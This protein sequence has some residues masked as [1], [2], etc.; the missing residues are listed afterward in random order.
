MTKDPEG[1][2]AFRRDRV[3]GL[4]IAAAVIAFGL[5]EAPRM[6]AA[7][8]TLDIYFVDVEGGQA[9]LV[10]TPA[11]ETLLVDTGFPGS[12]SGFDATPGDPARARDA[13]RILA[14]ARDAGVTRIDY[15]LI[16]HFHADHD[17]GVVELAQVLPIRTFVDHGRVLPVA[18]ETSR[19]TL[20]AFDRYAAVRAKGQHLEPAPGDRIPLKGVEATV[21]SG[22]GVTVKTPLPGAGGRTVGCAAAS[23][24]QEPHENPRSTGVRLQFGSFRFLD[25]GDLTGPPLHALACPE[26]MVGAVDVYLV[27]HHGG[28]DAA[29]PATFAA[30]RPRV[31]IVNNGP[32]KG[33]APELFRTLHTSPNAGDVYQLHTS[34]I[35]G[36]ENF[37]DERIANLDTSSAHWL[38]VSARADGS[39]TVTNARTGAATRYAPR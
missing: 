29:D 4:L 36:A 30:F 26:N 11:G 15:L 18:E 31:S 24:A 14:A 2:S 17:G 16:T 33:G 22:A 12:G 25:L 37:A 21:L 34:Q 23:P 13:Q 3:R 1:R 19:G 5:C 10:A 32:M 38:K 27:A 39:F 9:T 8:D 7:R 28:L 6:Q 35:A 20:A